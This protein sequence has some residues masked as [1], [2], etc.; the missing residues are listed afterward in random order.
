[1]KMEQLSSSQQQVIEL[2]FYQDLTLF[3][4]AEVMKISIGSVRTHYA[5]AKTKLAHILKQNEVS[6]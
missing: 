4:C 1:M 6:V 2:V 5:R 3:E